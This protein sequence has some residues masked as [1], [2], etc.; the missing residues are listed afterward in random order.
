MSSDS[1]TCVDEFNAWE[2]AGRERDG[3]AVFIADRLLA[4]RAWPELGYA[5]GAYGEKVAAYEAARQ[6]MRASWLPAPQADES[7][8]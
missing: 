2:R 8:P 1:L 5:L 3:M 6:A 4:D 7:A